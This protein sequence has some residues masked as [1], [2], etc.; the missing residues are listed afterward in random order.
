NHVVSVPDPQVM[1]AVACDPLPVEM[2]MRSYMTGV[3]STS[4]WTHYQKGVRKFCG[5]VLPEGLK[6]NQPLPKPILRPSTKAE[7]GDDD[8]SV[9]REEILAMGRIDAKTF[10][11]AADMAER[12]FAFGQKQARSRG[13]ILVDTKYEFGRTPDGK[14]V[15]IDEIH[16]PDSSR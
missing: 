12:L 11:T 9:S 15:I 4:I 13:M 16:T 14:I 7:K 2:V 3:T 6:K 10:D 5:H 8:V 1:V